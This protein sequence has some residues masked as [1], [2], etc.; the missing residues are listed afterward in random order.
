MSFSKMKI[1]SHKSIYDFH[2]NNYQAA[3]SGLMSNQQPFSRLETF[4]VTSI[5]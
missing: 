2:E 4:T 3:N 5:Q 1:K